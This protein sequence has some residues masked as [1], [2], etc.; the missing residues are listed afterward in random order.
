MPQLWL[1]WPWAWA[2]SWSLWL[3]PRRS[4]VV[5]LAEWRRAHGR[6]Q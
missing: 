5:D 3:T 1:L 6:S 4:N 2:Y